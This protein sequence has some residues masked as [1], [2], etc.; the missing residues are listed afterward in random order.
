MHVTGISGRRYQVA[1]T[2]FAHGKQGALFQCGG[3]DTVY[4]QYYEPR[5]GSH[6]VKGIGKL[7]AQGWRVYVEQRRAPGSSPEASINWP[8]DLVTGAERSVIGVLLPSVPAEFRRSEGGDR[9]L[10]FL[11]MKSATL[12]P[13]VAVLRV[14]VLIR[15]AEVLAYLDEQGLVHG[16]IAHSNGLWRTS[17]DLGAYLIDCDGV[18]DRNASP[19][20][21]VRTPFWTDPRLTEGLIP[22]HDQASDRYALGL[23]MYRTLFAVHG[24][25]GKLAGQWPTP[26]HIPRE[27]PDE[28][29]QLLLSSLEPLD[30]TP[31]VSPTT[32]V[33]TLYKIYFLP[34]SSPN[35]HSLDQLD[36]SVGLRNA[37][38]CAATSAPTAGTR[39]TG[40][41]RTPQRPN[42]TTTTEPPSAKGDK[43][44]YHAADTPTHIRRDQSEAKPK[45]SVTSPT[46]EYQRVRDRALLATLRGLGTWFGVYTLYAFFVYAGVLG[47]L[48]EGS[49]LAYGIGASFAGLMGL[50]ALFALPA[51]WIMFAIAVRQQ[52]AP[53]RIPHINSTVF[54]CAFFSP[55]VGA[56]MFVVPAGA[57]IEGSPQPA[58]FWW[59]GPAAA[60]VMLLFSYVNELTR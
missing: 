26:G 55:P 29:R 37:S 58:Q 38:T 13:P 3:Q 53:A 39:D 44:A 17:P 41:P 46:A 27:T 50:I 23:L 19:T 57:F 11:Y 21:P 42:A 10:S 8:F 32:W 54:R 6:A 7:A 12:Q 16:D 60:L 1:D 45:Q 36:I 56:L 33:R 2:P 51:A 25:L 52:S 22:A 34:D 15:V 9:D 14:G 24:N 40:L 31:R 49:A 35:K 18:Y 43:H 20:A 28:I 30:P 4:K 5:R 59:A 47:A 48:N